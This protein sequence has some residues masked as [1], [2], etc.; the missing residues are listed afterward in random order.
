MLKQKLRLI[1]MIPAFL[2]INF[3]LFLDF[4]KKHAISHTLVIKKSLKIITY[5]CF[6]TVLLYK[7]NIY[8]GMKCNN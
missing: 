4:V 2:T 6:K 8:N 3:H 5:V 1:Y 7:T